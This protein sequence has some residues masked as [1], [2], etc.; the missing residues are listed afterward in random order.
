MLK[1]K[2][3]IPLPMR[4]AGTLKNRIFPRGVTH[5]D[6]KRGC[7]IGKMRD[8]APISVSTWTAAL[9]ASPSRS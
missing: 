2:L 6:A 1:L 9:F 5:R 8:H 3:P 7:A 4:H